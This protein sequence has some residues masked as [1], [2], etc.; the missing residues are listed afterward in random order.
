MP[1][2]AN[3]DPV[4]NRVS[5]AVTKTARKAAERRF[6]WLKEIVSYLREY[7]NIPK[8]NFPQF[9]LPSDPYKIKD[10]LIEEVATET[11]RFWGLR[12]D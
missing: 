5:H 12:A 11:R 3:T 8:V 1:T 7:V 2:K 4:F 9:D 10:D 6:E